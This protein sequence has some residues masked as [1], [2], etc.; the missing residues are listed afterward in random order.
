MSPKTYKC[1]RPQRK[2]INWLI[3]PEFLLQY[4][5]SFILKLGDFFL[6]SLEILFS[7]LPCWKVFIKSLSKSNQQKKKANIYKHVC[8]Q[9]ASQ[10]VPAVKNLPAN[11]GNLRVAGS[12]PGSGR[13]PGEEHSNPLQHSYLENPMDR[14]AWWATVH[15]VTKSR[16]QPKWLNTHA[17][18]PTTLALHVSIIFKRIYQGSKQFLNTFQKSIIN[19]SHHLLISTN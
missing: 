9:R 2:I 13:C 5:H 12:I 19:L 7:K 3:F 17:H 14:G 18:T 6:F 1:L 11:A 4:S 15:R 16:I 8:Q 10:L